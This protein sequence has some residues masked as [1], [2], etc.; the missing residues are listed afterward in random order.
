MI[1]EGHTANVKRRMMFMRLFHV[2]NTFINHN[3]K[4]KITQRIGQSLH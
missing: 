3:E 1:F 4:A 2:K